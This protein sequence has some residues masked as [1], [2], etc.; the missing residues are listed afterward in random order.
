M[1]VYIKAF[2]ISLLAFIFS[3]LLS[4]PFTASV[5]S[6]FSTSDRS[7]FSIT[8]LYNSVADNR[9]VSRL[10]DNIVIVN[11]DDSDRDEIAQILNILNLCGPRAIGLDVTFEDVRPGD[12][13]LL[14]AI[15]STRNL[16][17]PI[18]L[19]PLP[20]NPDSFRIV[21]SS[22]FFNPEFP[23]GFSGS[24]LP[25]KYTNSTI[26]EMKLHYPTL[27]VEKSIPSFSLAL[28]QISDPEA[29]KILEER[30]SELE[31][32]NFYSRRFRV[33]EPDELIDHADE[34]T[35][36]IVI[37]GAMNER[38]DLHPTPVDALTPGVLIHSHA[39]G[40]ILDKEYTDK[41][42]RWAEIAL[43]FLLCYGLVFLNL[44]LINNKNDLA[45]GGRGFII[46]FTQVA[47]VLV[48]VIAGYLFFILG[49][50]SIDVTFTLL[51]LAFGL[52]ACDVWLSIE[53][54]IK[55]ASKKSS[56]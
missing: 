48:L 49:H 2:L 3:E 33:Y 10:D 43:A 5:S 47:A 52:F 25:S 19:V 34:L 42:S 21:A 35:N 51:M 26:R 39:L 7:D 29:A 17:Q 40:T 16:I 32:I 15:G 6:L 8:D 12:S 23:E 54:V 27:G 56:P 31:L 41:A 22:Y 53:A 13:T 46:R 50:L 20:A 36:R 45:K 30:N 44:F 28:A 1:K 18:T 14:A 11:I 9:A 24:G 55:V 37:I 38:G 4:G